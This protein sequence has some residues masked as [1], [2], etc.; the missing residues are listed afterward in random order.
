MEEECEDLKKRLLE[1]E[2]KRNL[3]LSFGGLLHLELHVYV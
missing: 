3:W 1:V 2:L